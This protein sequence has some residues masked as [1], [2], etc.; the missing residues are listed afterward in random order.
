MMMVMVMDDGHYHHGHDDVDAMIAVM[1]LISMTLLRFPASRRLHIGSLL[2]A[3]L[4]TIAIAM[5]NAIITIAMI[6]I[7]TVVA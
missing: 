2:N 7:I 6:V 4:M 5:T 3:C 1:T